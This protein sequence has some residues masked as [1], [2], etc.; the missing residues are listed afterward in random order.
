MI[1]LVFNE[2]AHFEASREDLESLFV[3]NSTTCP[4]V[5]LELVADILGN[6]IDSQSEEF[7][8]IS[9]DPDTSVLLALNF[10]AKNITFE[11]LFI[12]ASTGGDIIAYKPI[13]L[14]FYK[15]YIS[16]PFFTAPLQAE[17]I[18]DIMEETQ[19]TEGL[20]VFIHKSPPTLDDQD[21]NIKMSFS[22]AGSVPCGCVSIS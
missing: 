21:E 5:T 13:T 12:K 9:M 7:S 16:A 10:Q 22:G 4:I 1:Y 18:I 20:P 8:I 19:L 17:I 15:P 11:S 14:E 6:P 3:I 2:T